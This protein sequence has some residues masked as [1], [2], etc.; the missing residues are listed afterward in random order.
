[1][2]RATMVDESEKKTTADIHRTL[3]SRRRTA[4]DPL[5]K[6]ALFW[7][8][9]AQSDPGSSKRPSTARV[10]L[11]KRALFSSAPAPKHAE[12]DISENPLAN[13]GPIVVECS[14]CQVVTRIGVLD[15]VI[16]QLPFGA[17]LPRGRF[18]RRMTC[19]ACRRRVWASVTLRRP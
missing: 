6:R 10:P 16:F 1:V 17:W 8:P 2:T 9:G 18:D 12:A 5:G 19:P 7:V 3:A 15:F 4:P 14:A 13:Q 11:G